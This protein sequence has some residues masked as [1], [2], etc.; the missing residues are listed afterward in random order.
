MN[1]IDHLLEVAAVSTALDALN[2]EA[3]EYLFDTMDLLRHLIRE[4]HGTPLW[5]ALAQPELLEITGNTLEIR[6]LGGDSFG[7]MFLLDLKTYE[8]VT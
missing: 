8:V 6:A 2:V 5:Q 3:G 1:E 4:H 7:E